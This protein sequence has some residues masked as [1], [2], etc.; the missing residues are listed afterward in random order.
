MSRIQRALEK[1]ARMRASRPGSE[2]AIDLTSSS[3]DGP[4]DPAVFEA[5]EGGVKKAKVNRHIVG[6]TDP[7]SFAAEEYRK[8]RA[9]IFKATE[10]NFKNTLMVTSAQ[11]GEG[12]TVTAIN[13]AVTMAREIDHTVLLIDA[14]LRKP[15]VHRYLGI[16]PHYGLSDYLRGRKSLSEVLVKTGIGKLILLPAGTPPENPA[17]LIASERMRNLVQE[18]KDR[19]RDRYIICDTPP[20]LAAAESLS[21]CDYVDGVIVVIKA[22]ATD[23]KTARQGIS[24]LRDYNVL[25]AVLNNVQ[26]NASHNRYPYYYSRLESTGD[27]GNADK[28][29]YR[30]EGHAPKNR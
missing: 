17:E 7:Y 14:D 28:A 16:D 13:L 5:H 4:V 23:A 22:G 20:L 12:K 21:I 15:S 27:R 25:G 10:K 8:L 26:K 29:Q 6:I 9:K 1:A 11:P 30:D 24:L 2:G 18:V 19:Y 3:S